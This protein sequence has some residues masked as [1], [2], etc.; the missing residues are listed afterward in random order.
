MLTLNHRAIHL[1]FF[2]A[3]YFVL[4][5]AWMSLA[6]KWNKMDQGYS[7]GY[8]VLGIFLFLMI[9]SIRSIDY[10]DI[11]PNYWAS[12]VLVLAS[13]LWILALHAHI[14][15][16]QWMLLPVMLIVF[17]TLVFGLRTSWQLLF[18][19]LF[20]GFGIPFWDYLTELLQVI[21]VFVVTL[22][23]RLW[24]IPA[25]I[26]AFFVAIP[27]GTFEIAGGCSGLRYLLVMLTLSSLYGYLNYSLWTTRIALVVTAIFFG[28]LTNWVRVFIII[29]VGHM[30]NM[31]SD[32]IE[33]HDFL[34]W[35][36]FAVILIPVFF[37]AYKYADWFNDDSPPVQ[38]RGTSAGSFKITPYIVGFLCTFTLPLIIKPVASGISNADLPVFSGEVLPGQELFIRPIYHGADASVDRIFS[39]RDSTIQASFRTYDIQKQGKELVAYNNRPYSTD[40]RVKS[41]YLKNAFQ[42]QVIRH[43]NTDQL[44]LV[45][46]QFSIS[47]YKVTRETTAKLLEL[48][49]PLMSKSRSG[50]LIL[51]AECGKTCNEAEL[52]IQKYIEDNI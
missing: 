45:A 38:E 14:Q 33:D 19:A 11:K 16:I 25:F 35:I 8:L 28:L 10:N 24:D 5:P 30:T 21:T 40:W 36:L 39:F 23:L 42:Y 49:K 31:Q 1:G 4:S 18:P 6:Q 50:V 12:P 20:L 22:F 48:L 47:G 9:R 37:L 7:H 29:V 46:S 32:L 3:F 44:L 15:L 17:H 27:Q 43:R 26:E 52:L 34:G 51:A 2:V 41:V 13:L